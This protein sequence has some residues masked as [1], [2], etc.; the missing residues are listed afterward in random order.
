MSFYFLKIFIFIMFFQ[1]TYV[2][3]SLEAIKPF[4][5][6]A[7]LTIIS[8]LL[9]NENYKIKFISNTYSKYF[10]LFVFMQ[11]LSSSRIW[12]HGGYET[13]LGW[14]NYIII[15]FLIVKLCNTHERIQ[16]IILMI[17]LGIIYLSIFSLIN[18][19]ENKFA[20]RASGFGWYENGNDLV[21]ILISVI[22]LSMYLTESYQSYIVRYFVTTMMGI[23]TLTIF[24]SQSRQ[25]LLGLTLIICLS[26]FAS[27]R[28]SRAV[29]IVIFAIVLFLV[30]TVGLASVLLR[31]DLS[32]GL[33]GDDS[34]ENRLVQWEACLRMVKHHP[35]LGVGPNESISNMRSYG[36]IGGLAPHNTLIQVFAE[37]G[38]FGGVF[39]I[40][41][42]CYPIID[43][44]KHYV[45][46]KNSLQEKNDLIY[47]YLMISLLGFWTCAIFSNRIHFTILYVLVALIVATK[48]LQKINP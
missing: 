43:A 23:F 25:G 7:L 37:T 13:L 5:L 35:F 27:K 36:G 22:P 6:S 39:F 8:Y 38:I 10:L 16:S 42:A 26:L 44:Y 14:L 17:F 24:F 47:R 45:R 1:P 28:I 9:S 20:I 31:D 3:P 34:S 40:M 18:V 2:F 4:K 46:G 11:V 41:F 30:L 19:A 15:Y 33:L 48:N 12:F 21:L 29:R 32:N